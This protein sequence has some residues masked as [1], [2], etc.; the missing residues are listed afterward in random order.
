[1][2]LP[3]GLAELLFPTRCAGCDAPGA[4]LCD[5]CVRA[6]PLVDPAHACPR[7]GAPARD[8]RCRQCAGR[9]LPF[10][11]AR[12]AG[13]L[14]PPLSRA[15]TL[16]KDGGEPRLAAVL[17]ELAAAAAGEWAE[18]ADTVTWVPASATAVSRRGFD[19]AEAISWALAAAAGRRPEGLLR[20]ASG[21]DQRRLGRADRAE[22]VAGAFTLAPR[23]RPDARILLV[24]DVF[25][26]GATLGAAARV[27]LAA[28][29]LE[30][31]AIAVARACDAERVPPAPGSV[32]HSEIASTR[33]CGCGRKP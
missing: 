25:T 32:L 16:L 1:M 29:A 22:N 33:V 20:R 3:E 8:G 11:G 5:S 10:A 4:L 21:A 6:L 17:G 28:G 9:E 30:V 23:D 27:L 15:V 12:C 19:H 13:L 18:W 14:E 24:D 26:T 2:R 7:C 31:R